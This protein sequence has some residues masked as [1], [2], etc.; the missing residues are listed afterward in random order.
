MPSG[1][2]ISTDGELR[3]A[4]GESG[5]LAPLLELDRAAPDVGFEELEELRAFAPAVVVVD[6]D[7]DPGLGL[8]LIEHLAEASPGRPV[9][10]AALE[11]PAALLLEALRAGIAEFLVKPVTDRS[12]A[13][14]LEGLGR[15][16]D[17]S[18][19]EGAGAQGKVITFVGA[20]G[21]VGATMLAA[22]TAVELRRGTG[23]PVLLADLDV[24]LG[25]AALHFHLE[26]RYSLLDLVENLHRMDPD[27]LAS[28]VETHD[29]G[30]AVLAGHL[31]V[32]QVREL[33]ADQVREVLR[34]LRSHHRF[35]ILDMPDPLASFAPA[36]LEA[37]DEIFLVAAPDVPSLRNAAHLYPHLAGSHPAARVRLLVNR[38]DSRRSIPIAEIEKLTGARVY[39]TVENDPV[40]VLRSINEGQPIALAQG[41]AA[42]R[43]LKKLGARLLSELAPELTARRGKSS[44]LESIARLGG[45]GRKP[46]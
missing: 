27:L 4:I 3:R 30:V 14:A 21:G 33:D 45:R 7:E 37:S 12:L 24:A 44:L 29:S 28:F 2:I 34:L 25:D 17:A 23:L 40:H 6:L 36:V 26:P 35:V 31:A 20:K 10:A 15:R 38:F 1:A 8:K 43:D 41:S 22:G 5:L 19:E 9:L 18:T 42:A 32:S 13:E 11:P 39:G 46:A 16:R